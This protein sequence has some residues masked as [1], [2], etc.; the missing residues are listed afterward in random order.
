MQPA[1]EDSEATQHRDGAPVTSGEAVVEPEAGHSAPIDEQRAPLERAD[2]RGSE[3]VNTELH[4]SDQAPQGPPE[5]RTPSANTAVDHTVPDNG[6][7]LTA[8]VGAHVTTAAAVPTEEVP[9]RASVVRQALLDFVVLCVQRLFHMIIAQWT[10]TA[11]LVFETFVLGHSTRRLG[12]DIFLYVVAMAIQQLWRTVRVT[13][14]SNDAS[15]TTR[16]PIQTLL[17]T[18]FAPPP[19]K[20]VALHVKI[21]YIVVKCFESF[22]LSL[23]PFYSVARL[24]TELQLDGIVRERVMADGTNVPAHAHID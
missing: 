4:P 16:P 12:M 18:Y 24:E 1:N 3:S 6:M 7:P 20:P 17:G 10:F 8:H 23:S 13:L 5:R 14:S 11:L 21:V 22:I 9:T 15:S 19:G 2:T